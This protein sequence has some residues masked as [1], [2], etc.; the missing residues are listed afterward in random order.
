MAELVGDEFSVEETDELNAG[1]SKLVDR[2]R[3]LQE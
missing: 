1:L 2:L 3:Q